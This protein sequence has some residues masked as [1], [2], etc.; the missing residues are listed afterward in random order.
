[1]NVIDTNHDTTRKLAQLKAGG[2]MTII[3]YINPLGTSGEKTVKPAEAKAIAEA[4]LRL[5][6]V[7]EGWGGTQGR[8]V[9]RASGDRDGERCRDYAKTIGAPAGACVY[10]AVDVD[11]T[12]AQITTLARPYFE[13]IKKD[14]EGSGFRVG[15]YGP[16]AVC[17]AMQKANLAELTWLSN[18]MGWNGS[19]AYRDSGRWNLLQHLPMTV[20]G[21]DTDPDDINPQRSDI[22]DFVPFGEPG[23]TPKIIYDNAWIQRALNVLKANPPLNPDGSIG[24]MTLNAIVNRLQKDLAAVGVNPEQ[25]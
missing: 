3:R 18:A 19:R 25:V 9:D 23:P 10:F 13:E 21:L 16:G 11:M 1:M 5:G 4:G 24:P 14:F 6:L 22:G 8:G 15:V 2:I 12:N 7:C 17:D 20:A